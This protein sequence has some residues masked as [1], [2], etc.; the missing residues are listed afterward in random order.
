[1]SLVILAEY[2]AFEILG[3]RTFTTEIF[4]EFSIGFDTSSAC[5]LSLVIVVISIAVMV[6]DGGD[7]R[8]F[9]ESLRSGRGVTQV[10]T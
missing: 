7:G 10:R 2:G 8:S 3:Y 1:M 6:G 4:S 5:A 9:G